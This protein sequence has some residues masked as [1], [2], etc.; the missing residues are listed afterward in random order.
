MPHARSAED[1]AQSR[2]LTGT[3]VKLEVID[4]PAATAID[5]D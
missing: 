3:T 5:I 2:L 1:R 4:S